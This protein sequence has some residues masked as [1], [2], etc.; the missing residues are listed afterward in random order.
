METHTHRAGLWGYANDKKKTKKNTQIF[1]EEDYRGECS[2][3]Q[4]AVVQH[5]GQLDVL[6]RKVV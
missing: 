5:H 2:C 4:G 6:V 3:Q 1:A